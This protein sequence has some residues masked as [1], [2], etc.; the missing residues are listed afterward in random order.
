M[1]AIRFKDVWEM[2]DIKFI[3][4]N[5]T[6]WEKYWALKN[7]EFDLEKGQSLGIIG[8]N[9]AGKSTILKLIMGMIRPDRGEIFV[10]GKVSGLLEIGAGFQNELTGRENLKLNASM[11]GLSQEKIK[12]KTEAI[13]DF[14]DIGK[15]IDA[16]VKCYSQ[17]MFIRLAFAIAVYMDSD[18][19][20]IDDTLAVGDEYF[21]AKCINKIFE[22]KEQGKSI[23]LVTHDLNLL[24]RLC[25]RTLLLQGGR[26]IKD[27]PTE[28]VAPFYMH[29][30]GASNTVATLQDKD[31]SLIFNNGKIHLSWKGKFITVNSGIYLSFCVGSE[32]YSSLQADWK[33]EIN[34]ETS[35]VA[36]GQFRQ[37][38]LVL[39][40]AI[41]LLLN[42]EIEMEISY[43]K[44]NSQPITEAFLN[45]LLTDKYNQWF[46][47]MEAGAFPS[48]GQEDVK[49]APLLEDY[50]F[51]TN[52]GV[53]TDSIEACDMPSLIFHSKDK[54]SK[55]QIFNSDYLLNCRALQYKISS[56]TSAAQAAFSGKIIINP[57]NIEN[58]LRN[59]KE[60]FELS[61][62][63]LKLL[64][65]NGKIIVFWDNVIISKGSHIAFWIYANGKRYISDTANWDI[66]KINDNRIIVKGRWSGVA[67]NVVMDIA[68]GQENVVDIEVSIEVDGATVIDQQYLWFMFDSA[69]CLWRTKDGYGEFPKDFQDLP[70][71]VFP[72]CV[73]GAEVILQSREKSIPDIVFDFS[74]GLGT[75]ARIFNSDFY[76]KSRIVRIDKIEAEQNN[77]YPDGRYSSFKTSLQFNEQKEQLPHRYAGNVLEG[78]KLK[79][80]FDSGAGRMFWDGIELTKNLGIYTSFRHNGR[81]QDSFSSAAWE[82]ES[83]SKNEIKL[84]GKWLKLPIIQYWHILLKN[85]NCLGFNI[86]IEIGDNLKL[87][88][89]QTNIML[90]EKYSHWVNKEEKGVFPF[91]KTNIDDE[92]EYIWKTEQENCQISVDSVICDTHAV[93]AVNLQAVK[94]YSG[95]LFGILN[96][97]AYHRARVLRCFSDKDAEFEPGRRRCFK[98][99]IIIDGK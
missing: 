73:S 17:G 29:S 55:V 57:N 61:N 18:I 34:S 3:I 4:N 72:R 98:G 78:K 67:L 42:G 24:R 12:E 83:A 64:F 14:A 99:D 51:R 40:L 11:F 1:S 90:S 23:V 93:P 47:T 86:D 88:C 63:R 85:D 20:L 49:W 75:F 77:R 35:L 97:D 84:I 43:G 52:I 58:Y 92:W 68:V 76:N 15:F 87:E 54:N 39:K 74:K 33:I 10:S 81:W 79:F 6:V 27:G 21:Q 8:A 60:D 26:I 19:L 46:T 28:E 36:I 69:Y 53:K 38:S 89:L 22:L 96:S 50:L 25:P 16:P 56:S 62:G 45:I 65:D 7:I 5:E 41:K 37:P 82:L 59:N 80:L 66:K 9:G 44:D 32:R 31:T 30:L 13:I 91:F 71:D 94:A 2:Y 95:N 70:A 48:L